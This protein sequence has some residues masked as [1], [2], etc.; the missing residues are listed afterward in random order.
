MT[1]SPVGILSIL[2]KPFSL[3]IPPF[4]VVPE[5]F[6]IKIVTYG[7][8]SFRASSITSPLIEPNFTFSAFGCE[9]PICEMISVG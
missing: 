6:L 4:N 2:K 3:V 7:R 9:K 8:G 1:I 5:V